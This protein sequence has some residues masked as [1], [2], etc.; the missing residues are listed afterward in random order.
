MNLS[1]HVKHSTLPL[2]PNMLP[3][4]STGVSSRTCRQTKPAHG[5]STPKQLCSFGPA[6]LLASWHFEQIKGILQKVATNNKIS[7]KA[8]HQTLPFYLSHQICLKL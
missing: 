1:I 7:K 2:P 8:K 3:I 5:L 6:N 4:K